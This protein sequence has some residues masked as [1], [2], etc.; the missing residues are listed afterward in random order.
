V[1]DVGDGA[2]P[3]IATPAIVTTGC[4]D[5][6]HGFPDKRSITAIREIRG[7]FLLLA[8]GLSVLTA[9]VASAAPAWTEFDFGTGP[10]IVDQVLLDLNGDEKTDLVLVRG[11]EVAIYLQENGGF[12][13]SKPLQRFNFV[14]RAILWTHADLDGDGRPELL[15]LA[16]DGVYVYRW[17]RGRLSF[18]PR[19]L[20]ETDAV[21]KTASPD[22]VRWK[23]FFEDLDGDG[24]RDLLLPGD[25]SLLY[26]RGLGERRFADP[27]PLYVRPDVSVNTGADR[28]TDEL[29]SR[30]WYPQPH[31][32]EANGDGK[33]D[34]FFHQRRQVVVFVQKPGGRF[35]PSPSRVL[36]LQFAGPL[37][38][39]RFKLDIELPTRFADADGDGLTEIVATHMGRAVTYVFQGRKDLKALERPDVILRLPGITF[40]DYL[41]DLDGDGRQDLMLARTDRPGLWDIIKVLVT[42]EVPVEAFIYYGR[43]GGLF[44]PMPDARRR[45]DVPILFASGRSGLSVGTSAVISVSGDFDG[46]GRQDLLLRSAND[47]VAVYKNGGRSF[48]EDPTFEI[49]VTGM[50]G[51]RFIE[52]RCADLDGDGLSDLVLSYYSWDGEADRMSV[53]MSGGDR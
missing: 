34:I 35:G 45:I 5:K 47:R 6:A 41:M 37:P 20:L 40:G 7:L 51:Y 4:S 27:Q 50:D 30:Y 3:S 19:R 25:G 24:E 43:E 38:D 39:G 48:A 21:L 22:E 28:A 33:P 52:P 17:R 11:R 32:G 15:Y 23:P 16:A 29:R 31:V 53:I 2:T 49:T 18:L 10:R 14:D 36:P 9:H 46:D 42:K 26:Y 12:D 13:P 8:L 1:P 44:P